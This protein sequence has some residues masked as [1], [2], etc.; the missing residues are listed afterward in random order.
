MDAPLAQALVD[1]A[2]TGKS[3][4]LLV[5]DNTDAFSAR[6]VGARMA[7]R[8]LDLMYYIW[9]D[10]HCGRKL[11]REVLSAAGRGVKVR[12]LIDDINPQTSDA[13]YLAVDGHPNV[14]LRLFNPCKQRDR[15]LLRGIE[16]VQ[17][18]LALTRRMHG[19]AWIVDGEYAIVGGRNIGDEYFDAADLNFR[20]LDLLMFGPAVQQTTAI[21]EAY[22]KCTA[23]RPVKCLHGSRVKG[24]GYKSREP[25]AAKVKPT[26]HSLAE[27]LLSRHTVWSE[28]VRVIADPP[29]KV[30]GHRRR[31][32][33]TKELMPLLLSAQRELQIASPYFIP[34]RK[35]AAV[36][37]DMVRR[38][39]GVTVLTNS[40]A[41]TDV[42]AVHGAYANYRR[43][44]LKAGVRL[45]ELKP[46]EGRTDISVFG[47]KGASLH[48]KA[49]VVDGQ[50]G[51]IGSFNFDPRSI[52][53]NAEMGVLFEDG[54]LAQSV[55][56][57]LAREQAPS[58]SFHVVLR[59]GKMVWEGVEDNQPVRLTSDPDAG[60][61]RRLLARLVGWLPIEAQL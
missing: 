17:R 29:E 49:V 28:N 24:R 12:I 4:L 9:R 13:A 37:T 41:A 32:W 19:K 42:A 26:V 8:T 2:K 16:L 50:R 43:R 6:L 30:F 25:E 53:L 27:M 48:T 39:I 51:F 52:S 10:D 40:L 7:N 45:F 23:A 44:L 20:D 57:V 35:G 5:D 21:F 15:S 46:F 38:G 54:S 58:A 55:R 47:S 18:S 14:E 33:L 31:N 1:K 22:W 34:G 11:M 59:G 56:E 60:V 3:G 61:A 36:L